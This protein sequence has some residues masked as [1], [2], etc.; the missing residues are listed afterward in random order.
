LIDSIGPAVGIVLPSDFSP[1]QFLKNSFKSFSFAT[2]GTSMESKKKSMLLLLSLSWYKRLTPVYVP[3]Y[4]EK[5]RLIF[6]QFD[7]DKN[8]HIDREEFVEL[9]KK[10]GENFD[11][12][13]IDKYISDIDLDGNGTIEFEE[14]YSWWTSDPKHYK[15]ADTMNR[16]RMKFE[17][18]SIT[19]FWKGRSKKTKEEAIKVDEIKTETS[20][21][22]P[23]KTDKKGKKTEET[24]EKAEEPSAESGKKGKKA[25]KNAT[26]EEVEKVEATTQPAPT[27]GL[28]ASGGPALR[29]SGGLR[30][31]RGSTA[32]DADDDPV[33]QV[34][35]IT[36]LLNKTINKAMNQMEAEIIMLKERVRE[37]A[38]DN[39]NL[40]DELATYKDP[41]APE[42][43]KEN[44]LKKSIGAWLSASQKAKVEPDT[45]APAPA[46]TEKPKIDESKEVE[47][48]EKP[49]D[50][51]SKSSSESK[52]DSKSESESEYEEKAA[53]PLTK[54][55]KGGKKSP[56][57]DDNAGQKEAEKAS[58]PVSIKKGK[59]TSK[60][61]SAN[62]L[63]KKKEVDHSSDEAKPAKAAAAKKKKA[64]KPVIKAETSDEY[65]DSETINPKRASERRK[66][67]RKSDMRKSDLRKS[68]RR[69][70]ERN[71]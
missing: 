16:L 3:N 50:T 56:K 62:D 25:K 7:T 59:K 9:T 46:A 54:N 45:A 28:R 13:Q 52:S 30:S 51:V 37:L 33:D 60:K 57:K 34:R 55:Q 35:E 11:T 17:T 12:E 49:S 44:F 15:D 32:P 48:K 58:E 66:S 2:T 70:S 31:S 39:K 4:P 19:S 8:G 22:E 24:A 65:E 68:E 1:G 5:V 10:L 71:A 41:K 53:K 6:E 67:D 63:N 69:K 20:R 64:K 40:R 29:A 18:F 27:S 36:A 42:P 26:D 61:F 14:F 38:L 21:D 47:L 43:K 23:K